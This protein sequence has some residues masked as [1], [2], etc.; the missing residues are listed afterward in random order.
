MSYLLDTNICI[1]AL[2]G[3][4]AGVVDRLRRSKRSELHISSITIAELYF[5]A[6]RSR[7]ARDNAQ[8][9]RTFV[10]PLVQVPFDRKVAEIYGSA[11]AKLAARGRQIGPMDML[12]AATGLGHGLVVVTNN[13]R[14]FKRVPG[15]QVENWVSG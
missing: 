6:A 14:E 1:Y 4:D 7:R 9:V 3:S 2:N 13:Q 8:R 10:A 15:L 5:G 11:R 12:I